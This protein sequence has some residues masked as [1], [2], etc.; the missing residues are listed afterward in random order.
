MQGLFLVLCQNNI[1]PVNHSVLLPMYLLGEPVFQLPA[2]FLY[3][4]WNHSPYGKDPIA[5]GECQVTE[6]APENLTSQS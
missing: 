2:W 6:M 5:A 4:G 3:S 1:L